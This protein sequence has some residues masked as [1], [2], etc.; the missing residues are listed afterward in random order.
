MEVTIPIAVEFEDVDAYRIGH[1]ARLV[2]YLE[3]ARVRLFEAAGIDMAPARIHPVI[4][5]LEVRYQRTVAFQDALEVTVRARELEE[6]QLRLGYRIRRDGALVVRA[7]TDLA[8]VDSQTG[9]PVPVPVEYE[10]L[11]KD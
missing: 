3:R 9:E 11:F 2:F 5:K 6:Y 10:K 4:H 8:F 7:S 1:H